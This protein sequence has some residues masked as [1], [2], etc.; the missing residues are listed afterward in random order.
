MKEG[1]GTVLDNSMIV[2]G[3][4]LADGNAHA[5]EDL[6][7]ILAGGGGGTLRGNR[8]V[9]FDRE[10]PMCNLYMSLLDRMGVKADRIGDSTGKLKNI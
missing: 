2:F 8:H 10:T 6:P 5:H 7:V 4:G 9:R 3:S 1:A